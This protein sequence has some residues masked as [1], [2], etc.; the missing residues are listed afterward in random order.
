M[1]EPIAPVR[2]HSR[3]SRR[4]RSLVI[5]L[6]LVV[7][8]I[9]GI[10]VSWQ[11]GQHPSSAA[12]PQHLGALHLVSSITG[13]EAK[14]QISKLHGVQIDLHEA[15]I[16]EYTGAGVQVTAWVSEAGSGADAAWL[17]RRMLDGI[18]DG[19]PMF[20]NLQQQAVDGSEV[21]SVDSS[22]GKKHYFYR[23]DMKLVWL[24]VTAAEPLPVVRT[25]LGAL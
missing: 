19:N 7:A 3:Q 13:D 10:W 5:Q 4:R 11:A 8:L 12:V 22:D 9:V 2:K 15:Y 23:D 18:R 20:S 1:D 14:A 25:A 24:Q 16:A 6:G 17:L 21:Y